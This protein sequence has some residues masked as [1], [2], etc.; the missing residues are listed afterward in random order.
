MLVGALAAFSCGDAPSGSKPLRPELVAGACEAYESARSSGAEPQAQLRTLGLAAALRLRQGVAPEEWEQARLEMHRLAQAPACAPD[1]ARLPWADWILETRRTEPE[2]AA[3]QLHAAHVALG[4]GALELAAQLDERETSDELRLEAHRILWLEDPGLAGARARALLFR[5][6]PRAQD[7][8][9]PLYVELI[10]PLAPAEE[11]FEIRLSAAADDGMEHRA[12][13]ESVRALRAGGDPA[14]AS[15]LESIFIGEHTNF[16]IRRESMMAL[17]DL[18]RERGRQ[19]LARRFPE[20]QTDPGL[21]EF[22]GSLRTQ[23]NVTTL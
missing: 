3:Q 16:I 23:E 12:R 11:A 17:L 8:L 1:A 19:L 20:E 14:A 7:R 9:R 2:F 5:E 13:L 10:L 22:L 15:V 21:R 4:A 6:A 18:D